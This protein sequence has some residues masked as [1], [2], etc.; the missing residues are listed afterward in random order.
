MFSLLRAEAMKILKNYVLMGFLVLVVPV[1]QAA[2]LA[3]SIRIGT[4]FMPLF[5]PMAK[6]TCSLILESFE[7]L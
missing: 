7:L 3:I 1:G 4:A 5:C 2:F 6:I